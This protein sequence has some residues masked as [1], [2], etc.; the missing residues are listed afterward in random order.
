MTLLDI[1]DWVVNS[2]Q[3]G[4][5]EEPLKHTDLIQKIYS[6]SKAMGCEDLV[7]FDKS[8]GGYYPTR[9]AEENS[10]SRVHI[11]EFERNTF[12]TKLV[13]QLAVRDVFKEFGIKSMS[14]LSIEDH[15][16]AM[17]KVESKWDEEFEKHG[18][19]RIGVIEE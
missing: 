5:S 19:E 14:E 4:S 2:N 12:W 10:E 9:E 15:V 16:S 7:E 11:D 18:L 1:A 13:S 6:N 17:Y 8:M 3:D